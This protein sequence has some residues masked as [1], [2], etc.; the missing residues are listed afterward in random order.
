MRIDNIGMVKDLARGAVLLGTGGGGDPYVGQLMLQQQV[1]Q[2]RY[3]E[4]IE[5]EDLDDDAVVVSVA[6][7]GAPTVL[8][9]HLQAD[10]VCL[11]L[12][13][14]MEKILGRKVDA[15]IPAEVGGLNSVIPLALGAQVGLPV[16][17]ADGNIIPCGMPVRN[18][19]KDFYLGNILDGDTISGAWTGEK[20]RALRYAHKNNLASEFNMCRGCAY[21]QKNI[22]KFPQKQVPNS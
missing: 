9:E 13:E 21:A 22:A 16:I 8:V 3:V 17:D 12:L 2:G 6:G 15:L 4:V 1:K 10:E 19:T 18:H 5:A 7:I 14:Q 20:M 11:R